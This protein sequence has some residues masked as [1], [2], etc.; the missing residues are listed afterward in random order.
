MTAI[1]APLPDMPLISA[2]E[3]ERDVSASIT[4]SV[5]APDAVE[6]LTWSASPELPSQT[7]VS[8]AGASLSILFPHF[9][10]VWPIHEIRYL[11]YGKVGVC[12]AWADLPDEAE[13]VIAYR[14][15]ASGMRTIMLSVTATLQDSSVE[16]KIYRID[17]YPNYTPGRDALQE[18][19][20]ARRNP[21]R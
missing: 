1:W 2:Q 20:D 17:L 5:E 12:A 7:V 6:V 9:G 18:A 21:P 4:V 3:D 15:D 13:D 16:T 14:K 19:V 10:G 11:R 8:I